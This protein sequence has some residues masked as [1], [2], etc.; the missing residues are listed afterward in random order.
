MST[1]WKAGEDG[2]GE[3]SC[4]GDG[5]CGFVEGTEGRILDKKGRIGQENGFA[6][7]AQEEEVAA[8]FLIF[9]ERL[10]VEKS[11]GGAR[12]H[13]SAIEEFV[14][15]VM[16]PLDGIEHDG[17]IWVAVPMLAGPSFF[18][19]GEAAAE[20]EAE[21][22]GD[23][24]ALIF[25]EGQANPPG[26][27]ECPPCCQKG[28]FGGWRRNR[29]L[30]LTSGAHQTEKHRNIAFVAVADGDA[31]LLGLSQFDF[32]GLANATDNVIHRAGCIHDEGCGDDG[33]EMVGKESVAM[34]ERGGDGEGI[35]GLEN[36][37]AEAMVFGRGYDSVQ[38]HV[39]K[40]GHIRV[41]R[42]RSMKNDG[43]F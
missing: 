41:R 10:A 33:D 21:C 20:G 2:F 38:G 17:L 9:G 29:V 36:E 14:A 30:A 40:A 43:A 11:E 19:E 18:P 24:C 35:G 6:A 15:M 26:G 37:G 34:E 25:G 31:A 3:F 32:C 22:S 16:C 39:H 4:Q 13:G 12:V 1:V 23:G 28:G 7:V 5:G 27:M 42:A 8:F